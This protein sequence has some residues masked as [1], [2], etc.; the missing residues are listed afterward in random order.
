MSIDVKELMRDIKDNHK[1]IDSCS[2]HDFSI[3]AT[4]D[5]KFSKM[6]RCNNCGGEVQATTK[7]W[8]EIILEHGKDGCAS[9]EK[10][11]ILVN[12]S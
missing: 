5:K 2:K 7:R 6:Y 12:M 11:Y 8:Y 1:K 10:K 3:D 9:N 4:P